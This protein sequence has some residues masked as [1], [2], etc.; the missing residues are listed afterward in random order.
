MKQRIPMKKMQKTMWAL[1]AVIALV[2]ATTWAQAEP[3]VVPGR[4]YRQIVVSTNSVGLG[5]FSRADVPDAYV[6]V[7]NI[8][9]GKSDTNP[10]GVNTLR[11]VML[12]VSGGD[13]RVRFDG[14]APDA[15]TGHLIQ[16]H[17][18]MLWSAPMAA[19]ARFVRAGTN[20]VTISVTEGVE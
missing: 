7:E 2:L 14:T 18:F 3:D 15:V 5:S 6:R 8:R 9:G 13:V 17:S 20:D 12:S 11:V 1:C 16:N 4:P 10:G 19:A